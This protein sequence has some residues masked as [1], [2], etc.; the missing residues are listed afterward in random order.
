MV[1]SL[2]FINNTTFSLLNYFHVSFYWQV[3]AQN[4]DTDYFVFS[5][6]TQAF[7]PAFLLGHGPKTFSSSFQAILL[8]FFLG[9]A[10]FWL[11]S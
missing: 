8:S 4:V 11:F 9:K 3:R 6:G 1:Q 5:P 7:L 2:Q 10:F